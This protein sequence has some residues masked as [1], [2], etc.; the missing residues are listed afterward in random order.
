[1]LSPQQISHNKLLAWVE[2]LS[3]LCR[4]EYV[5]WCDGSEGEYR[6]LCDQLVSSG[7]FI[8]L[9]EEIRPNSFLSRSDPSDVA[10]VEDR[11]FICSIRKEDAGPMNNWTPPEEMKATLTKLF[12]GCMRGR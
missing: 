8:K 6:Q 2:D 4:P 9:N 10:R 1:M 12:S 7:T 3:R 5:H 11:T